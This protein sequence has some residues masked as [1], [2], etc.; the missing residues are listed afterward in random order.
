M[1]VNITNTK[2]IVVSPTGTNGITLGD[3][4][5][6][7]AEAYGIG[8]IDEDPITVVQSGGS[9]INQEQIHALVVEQIEPLAKPWG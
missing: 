3:M 4:K 9:L 2:R 7:L 1:S 8:F 5:V 6:A